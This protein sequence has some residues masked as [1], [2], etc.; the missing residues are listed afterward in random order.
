MFAPGH[1]DYAMVVAYVDPG[2]GF[3]MLQILAGSVIGAWFYFRR[4]V[5]RMINRAL[6]RSHPPVASKSLQTS[7]QSS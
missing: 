5:K 6:G 7:H 4:A 3:L 2:S 1:H